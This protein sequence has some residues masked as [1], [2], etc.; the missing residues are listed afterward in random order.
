[1][2][3]DL[4]IWYNLILLRKLLQLCYLVSKLFERHIFNAQEAQVHRPTPSLYD[5][6]MTIPYKYTKMRL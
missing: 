2:S 1:M 5:Y 6:F 4:T 3:R